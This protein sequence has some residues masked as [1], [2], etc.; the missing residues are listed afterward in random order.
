VVL[1]QHKVA[2]G[3]LPTSYPWRERRP[4]AAAAPPAGPSEFTV[5]GDAVYKSL[6]C[7]YEFRALPSGGFWRGQ[8]EWGVYACE[9]PSEINRTQ[10][11]ESVWARCSAFCSV[12]R[13]L[14]ARRQDA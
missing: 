2:A 10:D 4:P 12:L 14:V 3:G 11:L 13:A 8:P 1:N 5:R 7:T 9:L 6:G